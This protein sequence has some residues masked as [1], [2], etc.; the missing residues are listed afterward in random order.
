MLRSACRGSR[1]LSGSGSSGGRFSGD[2]NVIHD[3]VLE[4]FGEHKE[5]RCDVAR[6]GPWLSRNCRLIYNFHDK[7]PNV[8]WGHMNG[9]LCKTTGIE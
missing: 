6:R 4:E 1:R 7:N 9:E 2:L 8:G 3:F 5:S